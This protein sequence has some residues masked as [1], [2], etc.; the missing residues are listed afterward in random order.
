MSDDIKDL[1]QQQAAVFE[2]VS[3]Q[4]ER[5]ASEIGEAATVGRGTLERIDDLLARGEFDSIVVNVQRASRSVDEL[6]SRLGETRGEVSAVLQR[7]D[8]TLQAMGRI[9]SR[10]ERGEGLLG[11]MF[12]DEG[13]ADRAEGA[14]FRLEQLLEDIRANPG[15]YI[16]LSI[17]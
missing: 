6:A 4:V 1:I 7:A 17:F 11:R 14:V 8:T 16:R 12:M 2:R 3:V 10:I 13:L 5:A 15:R 9:A